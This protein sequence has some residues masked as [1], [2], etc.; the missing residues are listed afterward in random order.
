[1]HHSE[2]KGEVGGA[3]YTSYHITSGTY[4]LKRARSMKKNYE[5]AVLIRILA[6]A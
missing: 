4:A 6:G 2:T 3:R 5:S 1:M